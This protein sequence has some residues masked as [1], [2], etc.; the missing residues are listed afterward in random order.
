MIGIGDTIGHLR[1]TAELGEGGMGR[2]LL[3]RDDRLDR[4]VALKTVRGGDALDTAGRARLRREARVLSRVDHPAICQLYDL[5]EVGD[6]L[7]LAMERVDG[8]NLATRLARGRP[9][10][11]EAL[12]IAEQ[13]AAA[14]AAAH[15]VSVVHRDV[16]PDN[17][18]VRPDGSVKVVDFGIAHTER[19]PASEDGAAATPPVDSEGLTVTGE[20]FGTPRWMSPEQARGETATA[21]SD[22]YSFGLLLHALVCEAPPYP[23]GLSTDEAWRKAMWGDVRPPRLADPALRGLLQDLEA[24]QPGDRPSAV[25]T[26]ERLR[27]ILDRPRR[28]LVRGAGVAAMAGIVIGGI[29]S[30]FGLR[31]ARRSLEAAR[32]AE[33]AAEREAATARAVADFLAEVFVVADPHSG[34]GGDATAREILA[35]G[36]ERIERDLANQPLLRARLMTTIGEVATRI[37]LYDQA[38]PLIDGGLAI[39]RAALGPTHPEVADSLLARA[40]LWRETG[41]HDRASPLYRQVVEIRRAA[42]GEGSAET[43]A[44]VNYLARNAWDRGRWDEAETLYLEAIST[45]EGAEGVDATSL[46]HPLNNLGLVYWRQARYDEAEV[47]LRRAL[48][49]RRRAHGN[50]HPDVAGSLNNLGNLLRDSGR[51]GE[52]AQMLGE[53]LAQHEEMLGPDHMYTLDTVNNLAIVYARS[54]RFD[55]ASRLYHRALEGFERTFG[56]GSERVGNQLLNLGSL[57]V[58][59]GRPEAALPL[60]ERAGEVYLATVGREHPVAA[61]PIASA[62]D[63]LR[64]LGRHEEAE[65]RYRQALDIQEA[66]LRPGHPDLM[67]TLEGYAL[68]LERAGRTAEAAAVRERASGAGGAA[69]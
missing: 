64:D 25:A 12:R 68:M 7:L 27:H 18:M 16:K 30:G 61:Y 15:A 47:L 62:A 14:L 41:Q 11:K 49:I 60:L 56:P 66:L 53:S 46:A 1:V 51:Y 23:P 31:E 5:L 38:E 22:M 6:E 63:A 21:A 2:V 48:E 3:A 10:R 55:D 19:E 8:E 20:L 33:A 29:V 39:R 35:A 50:V 65:R 44:A 54:G 69:R 17:V 45:L 32:V 58:R 40:N 67:E 24:Q 57:E 28:R 42:T 9:P 26:L 34:G 4:D 37:G 59:R 13:V 43:A 36:A 52:A